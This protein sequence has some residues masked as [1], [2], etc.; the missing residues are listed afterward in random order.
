[1][2]AIVRST[3]W[4]L[5]EQ[6]RG[7]GLHCAVDGLFLAG[8]PLLERQTT[9]FTA[10]QQGDLETVLSRGYGFSV[11]LDR[12]MSGLSAVASALTAGDLCRAHIAAVH[13][14][15]PDLP[16]AFAR[17]D[18]QIED[19]ALKIDRIAKTTAAGDWNP[20]GSDWDPDK[21]P[22]TGAPPNPGWFAPT[23][24]GSSGDE[25]IHVT[26]VSDNVGNDG[27]FHLPPGERNDEAGDLLEWIANAKPE[28]TQ[29]IRAEI[30]RLY[31]DVGDKMGAAALN[32][33]LSDILEDPSTATRQSVLD[34]YEIYTRTDPAE[35]G[36][37]ARDLVTSTLLG[38]VFGSTR[39]ATP[40]AEGDAAQIATT[41]EAAAASDA[42]T[43]GWAAR[44]RAVEKAI[45]PTLPEGLD[46]AD[47][48]PVIDHATDDVI[49]TIKSIDLNAATY[50]RPEILARRIDQYAQNLAEFTTKRWGN[51]TVTVTENTQRQLIIAVP[52]GSISRMQQDI[53][54][55]AVTRAQNRVQIRIVPF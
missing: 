13:L 50:Q 28:D 10:R 53:I 54:D 26:P 7:L 27:R 52:K 20:A 33:A 15:I 34:N 38:P 55:S 23:D 48:F 5:S 32:E 44:G 18:M 11:S 35:V 41:A 3:V 14:R 40:T 17:L 25:S 4:C 49:T 42:W 31:F 21:H 16:D 47:N 43:L 2:G 6:K 45:K 19:V 30:K 12:V 51:A 39:G 36:Q 46:L 9:G 24:G 8:T 29:A 22:R 37:I 1:M